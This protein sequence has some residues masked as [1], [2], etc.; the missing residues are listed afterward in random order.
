MDDMSSHRK[1]IINIMK[2]IDPVPRAVVL[3]NYESWSDAEEWISEFN[4][5]RC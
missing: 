3:G 1:N 4:R 5:V 2:L